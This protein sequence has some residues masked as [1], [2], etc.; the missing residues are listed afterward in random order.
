MRRPTVHVATPVNKRDLHTPARLMLVCGSLQRRSSNRA[1]VDVAIDEALASGFVVDDFDHLGD[2]PPFDP[3]LQDVPPP[4]VVDW[5]TRIES[6]DA[7]LI[8]APEYAGAI[9]GAVKNALDW[10]VGF[11]S[12]YRK[13]V[14]VISAGT[15]GG[16]FARQTLARTLTWQGAYVVAELGISAPRTKSDADGRFT[17]RDTIESIHATARIVLDAISAPPAE[18][19]ARA[20]ALT[21]ALGIDS[22]H[23]A[24]VA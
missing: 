8:A 18:L 7:V 14:A 23:V 6:S 12:L 3:D 15:S 20:T 9:A 17:D 4:V 21:E 5:K 2:V 10:L 13:P 22:G 11:G 16:W 24:P 19:V 1:A